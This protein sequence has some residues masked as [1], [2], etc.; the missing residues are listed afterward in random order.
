[1]MK[2]M[3]LQIMPRMIPQVQ[4]LEAESAAARD[5]WYLPCAQSESTDDAL[6][7][8]TMPSGRQQQRVQKMAKPMLFE[9]LLPADAGE[10]TKG[11]P[12]EF[13]PCNNAVS[14]FHSVL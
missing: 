3:I 10:A 4:N 11:E 2:L 13:A 12:G 6:M 1:M 8:A 7:M 9:G 14:G 5:S